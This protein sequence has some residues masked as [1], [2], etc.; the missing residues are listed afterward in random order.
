VLAK[1]GNSAP[2]FIGDPSA[3]AFRQPW[4]AGAN[5]GETGW[6][7]WVETEH[8]RAWFDRVPRDDPA[9]QEFGKQCFAVTPARC[10][11]PAKL[12]QD[13]FSC[14]SDQPKYQPLHVGR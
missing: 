1:L 9:Q 4:L 2:A 3:G 7:I 10:V 6:L 8:S 11:V 5:E 14:V 13:E 12:T